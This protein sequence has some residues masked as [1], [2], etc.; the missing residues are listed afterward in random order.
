[1]L[2]KLAGRMT[3]ERSGLG[4]RVDIPAKSG[5]SL[6][7]MLVW[8]AFWGFGGWQILKKTL[9]STDFSVFNL[10]WL[11]F[12]AFALVYAAVVILWMVAGKTTLALD[13]GTL[14]ITRSIAGVMYS[15]RS[16]RTGEVRNLRYQPESGSGRGRKD[17]ALC[18]EAD[19]K[20]IR[21]ASGVTDAEALAL[22]DKMLQTYSFPKERALEYIDLSR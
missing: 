7:F 8:L 15:R 11:A 2:E 14:D 13:S 18:F 6:L 16:F 22:I 19:D 4:I 21:F 3:W 20:T 10:V 5:W 9:A 1:M 17:S 12:W